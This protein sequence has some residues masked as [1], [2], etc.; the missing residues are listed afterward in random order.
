MKHPDLSVCFGFRASGFGFI[1]PFV[2]LSG[3]RRLW[4]RCPNWVGDMTMAMPLFAAL[5]GAFPDAWITLGGRPPLQAIPEGSGVFDDYLPAGRDLLSD[6][7][8]IRDGGARR[9]T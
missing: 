9:V 7:R 4:V 5:R 1:V 8:R 2:D 3:V 6:T